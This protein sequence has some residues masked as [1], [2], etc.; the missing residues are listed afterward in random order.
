M[1]ITGYLWLYGLCGLGLACALMWWIMD[2]RRGTAWAVSVVKRRFPDVAQ[3]S[4]T[5]LQQW[6]SD[7]KRRT[8]ILVDARTDAE[9]AVSHLPGAIHLN[10]ESATELELQKLD[11][12]RTHV[13]YCSAGYRAC[14]LARKMQSVGMLDVRNLE[15]GIFAWANEGHPVQRGGQIVQEV[16]SYHRLFSRLLKSE[17]RQS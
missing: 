5:D 16:H 4:P 15:G 9:F 1:I 10:L 14:Q 8:P 6:L 13:V 3:I 2:H 7:E 17:R 12:L 11:P